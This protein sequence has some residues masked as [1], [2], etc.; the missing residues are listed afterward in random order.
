M[1]YEVIT[2]AFALASLSRALA[3]N[4][5]GTFGWEIAPVTV[6][7]RKGS[8]VIDKDEQPAKAAPDKIPQ[9]KPAFRT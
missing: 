4:N 3:A 2:D 6:A 9:L 5:D 1:L 7:G 8:V